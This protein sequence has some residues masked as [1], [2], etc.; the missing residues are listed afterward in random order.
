MKI[1]KM[2]DL[3]VGIDIGGTNTKF[4]IVDR[5]GN[6]LVGKGRQGSLGYED[7]ARS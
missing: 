3:T 2:K 1:T 5:E 6:V 7:F 4:G